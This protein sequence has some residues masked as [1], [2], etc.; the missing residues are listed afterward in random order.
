VEKDRTV[1]VALEQIMVEGHYKK[2]Y[3]QA[4]QKLPMGAF[5]IS[6]IDLI[7]LDPVESSYDKSIFFFSYPNFHDT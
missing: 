4:L 1:R 5:S 7:G 2:L 3:S 6:K